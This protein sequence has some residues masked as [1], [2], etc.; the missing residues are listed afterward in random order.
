MASF[1]EYRRFRIIPLAGLGLAA[2]YVFVFE[3]LLDRRAD[4]L[5]A[6]L[7]QAWQRLASSLGQTNAVALDFQHITNQLNQTRQDLGILENTKKKAIARLELGAAVRG[8]MNAPFQLV[9]YENDRSKQMDELSKVA[10]QQQVSIEPALLAGFPEHTAGVQ[11]PA[12]LWAALSFIDGVLISAVQCKV[13]TLHSLEVPLT[14]T[15]V[16]N[17]SAS[18]NLVEVPVQVEFTATAANTAKLIQSLALRGDEMRTAGLPEGPSDKP[19]LF[20]ERLIIKKQSPDK[21]DEVR[22]WLR[23]VGFVL[24]D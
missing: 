15:N 3:P 16:L 14:L 23:A 6:P 12:L 1:Q 10:K 21:P 9:D 11:Q 19:P 8:K 7:Q 17:S 5:N 22:V 13:A 20:V 2:Y 4:S 24:R 18:G